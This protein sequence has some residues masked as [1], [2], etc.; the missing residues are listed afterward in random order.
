[1]NLKE[2]VNG[3]GPMI[4]FLTAVVAVSTSIIILGFWVIKS[5]AALH[6]D[7]AVLKTEL[8]Y[9]TQSVDSMKFELRQHRNNHQ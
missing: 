8:R 6:E 1:M 3:R 2:R 5:N 7:I 4:T 9:L